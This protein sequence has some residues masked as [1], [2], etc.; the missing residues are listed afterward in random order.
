MAAAEQADPVRSVEIRSRE[1]V[2]VI[3]FQGTC[4][5]APA[6]ILVG[7][8]AAAA[9]SLVD[10]AFDG[11]GDVARRRSFRIVGRIPSRFPPR[12]KALLLYLFDQRVERLLEGPVSPT[13]VKAY[14]RRGCDRRAPLFEYR[15]KDGYRLLR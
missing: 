5:A 6:A 4:L 12:G 13:S 9:V 2:E 10:L 3:E 11:V 1:P 14:L 15:G 7:E 8:G